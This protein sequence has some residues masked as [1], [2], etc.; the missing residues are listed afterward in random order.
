M[1]VFQYIA[2]LHLL[3]PFCIPQAKRRPLAFVLL[4]KI[5]NGEGS[6]Y[7]VQSEAAV[8]EDY[9]YRFEECIG[10]LPASSFDVIL[11]ADRLNTLQLKTAVFDAGEGTFPQG[12]QPH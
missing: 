2:N 11:N 1:S 10:Y 12:G 4:E 9:T 5:E 6:W 7:K 8:A 3:P